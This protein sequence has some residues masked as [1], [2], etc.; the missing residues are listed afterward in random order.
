MS[1][2]ETQRLEM[3]AHARDIGS[4][5]ERERNDRHERRQSSFR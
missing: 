2:N 3:E 1:E 5:L 4:L